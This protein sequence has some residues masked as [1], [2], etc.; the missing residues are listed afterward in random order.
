MSDETTSDQIP[1]GF[2]LR[3]T[4]QGHRDTI[5]RIAWSPDG[6]TLASAGTDKVV[7]LWDAEAGWLRRTLEG[8]SKN[9]SS[10][11]WSPD[12]HTLASGGEDRAVRLWDARTGR[13]I[14]IIEG[15][16][17]AVNSI[18]ISPSGY[19]LA[20]KS[21]DGTVRLWRCDTGENVAV[22]DEP[23]AKDW[24]PS[25][26]FHP[27]AP[28]LATLGE[29]DK[30]IRIWELDFDVILGAAYKRQDVYTRRR[31]SRLWAIAARARQ[32]WVGVWHMANL[33]STLRHT[34]SSSG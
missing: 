6:R 13:L 16:T 2:K 19:L 17:D 22:L 8:H 12:G 3:H 18:A 15:H 23:A 34:G 11:A 14:I 32:V 4:L 24:P 10:I 25:L 5:F 31:R 28:V 26:A 29:R 1:P 21:C 9:V 33:K 27:T 20:S 7:R 30:V